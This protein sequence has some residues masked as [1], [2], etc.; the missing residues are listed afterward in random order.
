[1]SF[2][3]PVQVIEIAPAN[4]MGAGPSEPINQSI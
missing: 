1:V 4:L 2:E 3:N